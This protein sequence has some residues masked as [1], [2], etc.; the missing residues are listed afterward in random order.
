MTNTSKSLVVGL[1]YTVGSMTL[2]LADSP[3]VPAGSAGSGAAPGAASQPGFAS[4]LMPFAMM[5]AVVYFLMI[6]PQQ[7]K[8]KEQQDMMAG[9]KQGDEVLTNSGILGKI[10]GIADKL[11]T[12][13][14]ADDVRVK[15]L[16]SQISQVVQGNIK[17]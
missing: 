12:V 16:K 2:A 5:F 10:T 13:E 1:L 11:V 4:M 15:M 17:E 8:L 14:I 9:L 6:R 3:A 7:K